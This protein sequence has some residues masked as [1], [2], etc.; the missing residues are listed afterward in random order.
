MPSG[1]TM[2]VKWLRHAIFDLDTETARIAQENPEAAVQMY[3]YIRAHVVNLEK[4]PESGKPGRIFGTR[5]LVVDRYPYIIPYRV[6]NGVVEILRIFHT[7]REP[8]KN[9]L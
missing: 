4:F 8:P 3:G 9:W 1:V 5:E 7:R 6:K 2:R